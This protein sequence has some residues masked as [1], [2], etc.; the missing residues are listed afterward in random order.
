MTLVALMIAL[1]AMSYF[2]RTIMSIA[3]PTVM[4]EFSLSETEMGSVYSMFLLSYTLCMTPGGWL[5]DRFGPRFVLTVS[6]FGTALL[7]GLTALCGNPGLG[8][9][10]GI[11]PSFLVVRFLFGVLA[12]PLYPATGRMAANWIPMTA[13][14][15]VQALIMAGSSV[16]AAISP[17]LFAKLIGA[18]GW[19]A[20]FWMAAVGAAGL[21][22]VW[23][24]SVHDHPPGQAEIAAARPRVASQWKALLTD[25]NLLVLTVG[26]FLLNYFEYIFFY[27]I[28]YY[29]GQIRHLGAKETSLATSTLFVAFA[30][31]TPLGGKISDRLVLRYG[32][33]TGRRAVAMTAMAASAVLLFLGASG[34]GVVATVALLSFAFGS[35]GCAEGPYWATAIEISGEQAG[36]ACGLFNT[37]GNIGGMLAPIVT[38]LIATRFG[39]E[40]GLYFGSLMVLLGVLTWLLID[41][42]KKIG[43]AAVSS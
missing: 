13:Q 1:S 16:G 18:Y 9:I 21:G 5:T 20:P 38:P 39:W 30:V 15:W 25:R 6:V 12:A 10:F 26:Y 34:F 42:G 29:F 32:L 27:W 24:V 28:Y 33:K 8:A 17:L 35:A 4:K 36:A 31:M 7:T 3:G 2:D 37:G 41:P 11:V 19:R 23:F 43:Y 40:G 14:G 22:V